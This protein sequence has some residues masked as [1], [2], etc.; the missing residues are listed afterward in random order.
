[1]L[2]SGDGSRRTELDK[3]LAEEL[4][5][6]SHEFN[7]LNWWKWNSLHFPILSRMARDVWAIPIST[8][9]PKSTSSTSGRILD[10]FLSSLTLIT[11]QAL[12]CTQDWLRRKRINIEADLEELSKLEEGTNYRQHAFLLLSTN[13]YIVFFM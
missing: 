11:L 3:Y 12:I 8:V 4:E 13:H 1:M 7:I 10:G 6:N 2:T 9:A 5:E